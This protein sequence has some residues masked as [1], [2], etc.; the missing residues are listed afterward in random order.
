MNCCST[1]ADALG[2][3]FLGSMFTGI[4]QNVEQEDANQ[5]QF[6]DN[7]ISQLLDEAQTNAKGP[8]PAS[9]RFIESLPRV[10]VDSLSRYG[11]SRTK[12]FLKLVLLTSVS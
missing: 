11:C 6:L 3:F 8:P 12:M 9:E 4:R 2:M 7:L 1:V 10:S 5:Q